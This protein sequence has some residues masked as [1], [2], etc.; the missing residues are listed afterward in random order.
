[1]SRRGPRC[2]KCGSRELVLSEMTEV[3]GQ[4]EQRHDGTLY[5]FNG[6]DCRDLV[7]APGN[8]TG[9]WARCSQCGHAWK[10]RMHQIIDHPDY[11]GGQP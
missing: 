4:I 8:I 11:E 5:G 10:T 9:V 3:A 1:M 2:S 7:F 6:P